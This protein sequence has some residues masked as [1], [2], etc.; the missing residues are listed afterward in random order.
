MDVGC[1]LV[2]YTLRSWAPT[3]AS[4]AISAVAELLVV[5]FRLFLTDIRAYLHSKLTWLSQIRL[6]SVTF[7]RHTQGV[8]TFGNISSPFCTL[9]IL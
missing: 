9:A 2:D 6:S 5:I 1:T 7:V 8:E 3:P 4:R